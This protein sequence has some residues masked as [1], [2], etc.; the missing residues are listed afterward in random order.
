LLGSAAGLAGPFLLGRIVDEVI[1]GTTTSTVNLLAGILAAFIVVQAV[2]TRIAVQ[3]SLV[4]GE[5][6]FAELRETF[7]HRVL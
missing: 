4:V 3:R 6:V 2:L 7:M 5:R 1:A